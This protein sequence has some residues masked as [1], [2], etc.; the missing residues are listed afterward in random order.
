MTQNSLSP[1]ADALTLNVSLADAI[2][3]AIFIFKGNRIHYANQAA[4]TLTGY[5]RD[6]LLKMDFW[7]LAEPGYQQ[8]LRQRGQAHQADKLPKQSYEL[9]FRTQNGR[10]HWVDLAMVS[11]HIDDNAAVVV[12]AVDITVRKAASAEREKLFAGERDQRLL[13][14]TLAEVTLALTAHTKTDAVL[15]E[16]LT[17]AQRIVPY[18]TAL[19]MLLH[20]Q[21]LRATRW[22]GYRHLGSEEL[23][24]TLVQPLDEFPLDAGVIHNQT[25]VVIPDT[26]NEP[27]WVVMKSTAWI[28]ST[29]MLPISVHDRTLGL[30]R[31][32][33]DTPNEFSQRDV[34]RLA[35][36]ANAAAIALENSR[37]YDQARQEITE[38]KVAEM[39][40]QE[41]K[42]DLEQTVA[43][44]TQKLREINEQLLQ[45]INV[46]KRAQNDLSRVLLESERER[47]KMDTIFKS[48]DDGLIVTNAQKR[49]D[50]LNRAAEDMLGVRLSEVINQRLDQAIPFPALLNQLEDAL[51][52]NRSGE[53][54]DFTQLSDPQ[55]AQQPRIIRA[56]TA[57]IYDKNR[58]P[59]GTITI[60]TDVTHEREIDQMKTDFISTAAHELRTPLTTIRGFSELLLT[61]NDITPS[62]QYRYLEMINTQSVSLM[63]IVNDLLDISRIESGRGFEMH[64]E[65][66]KIRRTLSPVVGYFQEQIPDR[67][68]AMHLEDANL[69]WHVDK[70]KI[71]QVMK[72]LLSN[73]VKYSETG[74]IEING[75]HYQDIPTGQ[76][77]YQVSISDEGM[78]MTE[79][80]VNRVFEK[81][82]RANISNTAVDGTGLGMAIVKHIVE[83]HKGKIWVN[84]VYNEGTTITF[85]IPILSPPAPST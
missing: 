75:H 53:E 19:I 52:N 40:L 68:F 10:L 2:A 22:K 34:E 44:R 41:A 35:P 7:E 4:A 26:H 13:A 30:L 3:M 42:A 1:T 85:A 71:E 49:I 36:L 8:L 39:K 56:R 78:G 29:L 65:T 16:I 70:E 33:A 57:V 74:P 66:Q 58:V 20:G 47:D 54:L 37:L 84:S 32:D 81:F 6:D 18:H 73:A 38:R 76:H 15:D 11:I 9:Q 48:I 55:S 83:A 17:Q 23:I 77:F 28:R 69:K 82:Y 60:M 27:T 61:R 63:N 50:L 31:F 46:R 24:S 14:E 5:N 25:P 45:E 59:N 62:T 43:D 51:D 72:N 67:N 79:E 80:Q 12:T 64:P 21:E